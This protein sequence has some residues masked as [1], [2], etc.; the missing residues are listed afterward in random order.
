MKILKSEELKP[1][2]I[3]AD[4]SRLCAITT[5]MELVGFT[6]E[7]ALSF[8]YLYGKNDYYIDD[9]GFIYFTSNHLWGSINKEELKQWMKDYKIGT[10]NAVEG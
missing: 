6:E 7:R 4:T 9:D 3:V 1:G 8:K 2:M 5:V 10:E